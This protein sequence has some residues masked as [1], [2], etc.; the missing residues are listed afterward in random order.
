MDRDQ[1]TLPGFQ[2]RTRALGADHPR[3]LLRNDESSF[4]ACRSVRKKDNPVYHFVW[5]LGLVGAVITI[6]YPTFLDQGPSVFYLPTISGLLHHSIALV[7]VC[8]LFLFN[9]IY[10]TYKK[11]Y[12]TFFGFTAYLTVG[13]F[14]MSVFGFEDSFHI[15]EPLLEG[16]PLTA[17]VTAPIYAVGYA[18]ILLIIELVRKHTKRRNAAK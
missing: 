14:Q 13:A 18:A 5:S 16:T 4:G 17:W 6:F 2:I 12:C 7:M 11:W 15:T 3:Q 9:Q 10:V 8:A 1:Q